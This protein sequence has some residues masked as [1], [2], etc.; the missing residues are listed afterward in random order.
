MRH[1][2][3]RWEVMGAYGSVVTEN[4]FKLVAAVYGDDPECHDDERRR[5]NSRLIAAAPEMLEAL[6][7]AMKI[8]DGCSRGFLGEVQTKIQAAISKATEA[9]CTPSAI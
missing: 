8:G 5:A 4:P 6:K 7:L 9:E 2:P 1:T 3:G